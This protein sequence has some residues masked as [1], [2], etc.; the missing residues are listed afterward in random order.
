MKL[1]RTLP[2]V[3]A[4]ALQVMPMMRTALPQIQAIAPSAWAIIFRLTTGAVAMFGYHAI[5]SASSIAISPSTATQGSLYTGTIT[6]SGSHAGSVSAMMINGLCMS[7]QQNLV[8]GLKTTYNGG[9]TAS[10]TGTPTSSGNFSFSITMYSCGCNCGLSD[11]RSTTLVVNPPPITNVAP[12][13][14][15]LPQSVTAQIGSSNILFSAGATGRPTPSYYWYQGLYNS[16]N[17]NQ[18]KIGTGDSVTIPTVAYATA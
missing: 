17:P 10:V 7:S 14:A 13:M 1:K 18:N 5:S 16:G 2:L 11:T 3:V 12:S 8:D 15:A 9:Y 6:Y 4:A